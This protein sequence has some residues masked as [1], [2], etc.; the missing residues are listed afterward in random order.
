VGRHRR[1]CSMAA[2]AHAAWRREDKGKDKELRKSE[3]VPH[4]NVA[5]GWGGYPQ[6]HA[7]GQLPALQHARHATPGAM[8]LPATTPHGVAR[9]PR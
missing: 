3:R 8:P 1:A 5:G 2:G 4:A 6:Q 9:K 7:M